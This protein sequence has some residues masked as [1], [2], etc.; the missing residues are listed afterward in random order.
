MTGDRDALIRELLLLYAKYG[1][2]IFDDATKSLKQGALSRILADSTKEISQAARGA[3]AKWKPD[4][5]T[6]RSARK[7]STKQATQQYI[8]GLLS[9]EQEAEVM[10]ARFTQAI[11]QRAVLKTPSSLKEYAEALGLTSAVPAERNEIARRIGVHLLTLPWQDAEAI[12]D[13]ARKSDEPESS[14]EAWTNIIV[15]QEPER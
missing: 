11:V 3:E 10:V 2:E 8:A 7:Q 12:M 15:K 13:A 4:P 6:G 1:A 14:L 5:K 9:S